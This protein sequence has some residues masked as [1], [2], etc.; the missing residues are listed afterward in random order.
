[1]IAISP[2]LFLASAAFFTFP[3]DLP[4]KADKDKTLPIIGYEWKQ[5][6]EKAGPLPGKNIEKPPRPTPAFT[7]TFSADGIG[8]NSQRPSAGLQLGRRP[9]RISVKS[10]VGAAPGPELSFGWT[11]DALHGLSPYE[12]WIQQELLKS[13]QG[14]QTVDY[15]LKETTTYNTDGRSSVFARELRAGGKDDKFVSF[16]EKFLERLRNIKNHEIMVSLLAI[17]LGSVGDVP[18]KSERNVEIDPLSGAE[19]E[20]RRKEIEAKNIKGASIVQN[21]SVSVFQ[22]GEALISQLNQRSFV[23]DYDITLSDQAMIADPVVEVIQSGIVVSAT[24]IFDPD[25][26]S[27]IC[28]M[29]IQIS[30]LLTV[31]DMVETKIAG[32]ASV[33]IQLPQTI[34]SVWNSNGGLA[35][36]DGGCLRIRGLK[37]VDDKTG[38][39]AMEFWL[40]FD[41]IQKNSA[42][43]ASPKA[44]GRV[45]A[46]DPSAKTVVVTAFNEKNIPNTNATVKIIT[47]DPSSGATLQIIE[48]TSN[49]VICKVTSGAFPTPGAEVE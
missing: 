4:G 18:N 45:L 25:A 5:Q 19:M 22:G 29:S 36:P 9:L 46:T 33:K 49:L 24:P 40:R 21:Q 1:M 34:D 7:K 3:Q 13:G 14:I 16:T 12:H 23:T 39:H 11:Q 48:V 30:N 41:H 42:A 20:K 2:T 38:F 6:S 32:G 28:Y 8:L 37:W 26:K 44:W 47:N 35:A 43:P 27:F 17:D 10:G 31:E 15:I